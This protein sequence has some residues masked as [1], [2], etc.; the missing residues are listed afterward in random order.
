MRSATDTRECL[1]RGSIYRHVSI[2]NYQ[3]PRLI[4][5]KGVARLVP[6]TKLFSIVDVYKVFVPMTGENYGALAVEST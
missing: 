4:K 1:N 2:K 5:S 6:M 3:E